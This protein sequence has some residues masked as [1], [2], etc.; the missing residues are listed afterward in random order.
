MAH[1]AM[2]GTVR[3]CDWSRCQMLMLFRRVL[4]D[5][6]VADVSGRRV[7]RRRDELL[8]YVLR[9]PAEGAVQGARHR[10][11]AES[12]PIMARARRHAR[13]INTRELRCCDSAMTH[14]SMV[15]SSSGVRG[16]PIR[17][18]PRASGGAGGAG[19]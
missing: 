19:G 7:G 15:F 9:F 6:L 1:Q 8:D 5:A 2:T 10:F 14:C 18:C 12:N 16:S 13:P 17:Q 3:E 4:P 11:H